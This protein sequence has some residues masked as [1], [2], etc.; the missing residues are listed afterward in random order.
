MTLK[1][2]MDGLVA[3]IIAFIPQIAHPNSVSIF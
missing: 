2:S 3:E 1:Q